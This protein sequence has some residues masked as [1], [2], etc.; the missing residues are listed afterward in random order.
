M[1][2]IKTLMV[3]LS[4]DLPKV[5]GCCG[6]CQDVGLGS[7]SGVLPRHWIGWWGSCPKQHT[8]ILNGKVKDPKTHMTPS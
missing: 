4:E 6:T 2:S 7:P 1:I 8:S 3:V 5:G